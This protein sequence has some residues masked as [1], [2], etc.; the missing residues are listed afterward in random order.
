MEISLEEVTSTET[1]VAVVWSA[2]TE[3]LN[4]GRVEAAASLSKGID[5]DGDADAA[6][7]TFDSD[8]GVLVE[9]WI[10]RDGSVEAFLFVNPKAS[11][12]VI[13]TL[14]LVR[15]SAEESML[16]IVLCSVL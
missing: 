6:R 3:S 11:S 4:E 9:G 7:S 16:F 5:D 15:L 12:P 14:R 8:M 10:F 2:D 13:D 1:I